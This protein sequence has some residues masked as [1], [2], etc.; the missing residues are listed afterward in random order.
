MW[1]QL[2]NI[3]TKRLR[4]NQIWTLVEAP[5]SDLLWKCLQSLSQFHWRNKYLTP[6][7]FSNTASKLRSSWRHM[8]AVMKRGGSTEPFMTSCRDFHTKCEPPG[9]IKLISSERRRI[10]GQ[11]R[12]MMGEP[13][14]PQGNT[15]P[16][17]NSTGSSLPDLHQSKCGRASQR[18]KSFS[19]N[20]KLKN[21]VIASVHWRCFYLI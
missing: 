19:F 11:T 7:C 9:I 10:W 13:H 21:F 1:V 3:S 16:P 4:E 18:V 15:K 2:I 6:K 20:S 8:W 14:S 12:W 5:G 17:G